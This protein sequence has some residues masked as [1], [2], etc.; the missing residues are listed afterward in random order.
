MYPDF[1][2]QKLYIIVFVFLFGVVLGF[3]INV[4]YTEQSAAIPD[5]Q[6]NKSFEI[7]LK[8]WLLFSTNIKVGLLMY[9]V[10]I[11]TLGIFSVFS[12][13]FN[14]AIL[15]IALHGMIKINVS[16]SKILQL[17]YHLPFEIAAI[18]FCAALG[19][20]GQFFF[21]SGIKSSQKIIFYCWHLLVAISLFLVA[22][23]I[24]SSL[25]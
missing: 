11:T 4:P 18:C 13:A 5:S 21:D 24:E 22:A 10:G 15:G 3:C 2:I 12:A 20:T 1:F 23:F 9:I 17:S 19:L 8:P 14:G 7:E 25:S 16:L 6:I